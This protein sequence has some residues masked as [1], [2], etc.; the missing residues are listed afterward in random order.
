MRNAQ[1]KGVPVRVIRANPDKQ[2]PYGRVFIYDG[3]YDVTASEEKKGVAG[4]VIAARC[5]LQ[6]AAHATRHIKARRADSTARR[7]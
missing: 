4:C 6:L 7:D 1:E 2:A 5:A 3:L